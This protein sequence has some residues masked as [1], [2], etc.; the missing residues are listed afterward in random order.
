MLFFSYV[1]LICFHTLLT[2]K[3]ISIFNNIFFTVFDILVL[4]YAHILQVSQ[5]HIIHTSFTVNFTKLIFKIFLCM[6]INC[7]LQAIF[8]LI[9]LLRKTILTF[10][11]IFLLLLCINILRIQAHVIILT[12]Y[13]IKSIIII[14]GTILHYLL[15]LYT[16]P[17]NLYWYKIF[18]IA[19]CAIIF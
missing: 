8:Y 15:S 10:Y 1:L 5:Y 3:V 19:L 17:S 16:Y 13:T 4:V 6:Y 9:K 14:L 12:L 11:F 18:T 2:A 7:I